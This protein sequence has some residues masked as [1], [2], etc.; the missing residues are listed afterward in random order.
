MEVLAEGY[1]VLETDKSPA[2]RVKYLG[3]PQDVIGLI[4]SGKLR[5]HILSAAVRPRSS[6]RL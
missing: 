4:Q 3:S 5:E 6:R 1:N 2:G